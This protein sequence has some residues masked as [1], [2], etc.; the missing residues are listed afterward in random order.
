MKKYDFYRQLEESFDCSGMCEPGL[1]YLTKPLSNGSPKKT[2]LKPYSAELLS[3]TSIIS[4]YMSLTGVMALFLF[5]AHI[6]LL[7]R[8]QENE[9]TMEMEHR[10][11]AY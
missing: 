4:T 9:K 5:I 8:P 1:F 10:M 2:C 11:S 7:Y 3:Y 6:A